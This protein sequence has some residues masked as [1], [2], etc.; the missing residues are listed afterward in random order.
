LKPPPP[1]VP[2]SAVDGAP[3]L[4]TI[5]SFDGAAPELVNGRLAMLGFVAALGA[6]VA[7]GEAV[8]AQLQ[9]A[10][11]AILITFATIAIASLIPLIEGL[12]PEGKNLGPLNAAAERTN[13][14]AAC[15]ARTHYCTASRYV[16]IIIITI[17]LLF[18]SIS[19]W[20]TTRDD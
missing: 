14:R 3:T 10:P 8:W 7:S 6:E 16:I 1:E 5:M 4:K 9:E 20:P 17:V 12:S 11:G 19:S 18:R 13:G 2:E 15:V